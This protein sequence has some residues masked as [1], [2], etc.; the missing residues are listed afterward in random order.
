MRKF[1]KKIEVQDIT[2]M[3]DYEIGKLECGDMVAKKT[4]NMHHCYVVSYKEEGVG[5]CLS[6]SACGYLETVSYDFNAETGHWVYNSTDVWQA[7]Q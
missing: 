5:I 1:V 3:T 4:N 2:K 7:Q 6:Y